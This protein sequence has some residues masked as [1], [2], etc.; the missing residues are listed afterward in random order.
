MLRRLTTVVGDKF[1]EMD[2]TIALKSDRRD[3]EALA[4][5]RT[6]RG[7]ALMDEA[8]VFLSGIIR[9]ADERL[10]TGRRRAARERRHA[11]LGLDRRRPRHRAGGGRRHRHRASLCARDR[12]GARRGPQRSTPAS[13][14]G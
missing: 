13:R 6:N 9:A 2:Q 5:L 14:S 11:A 12:A 10:T 7:K 4:L 3:A 1:S 8:N